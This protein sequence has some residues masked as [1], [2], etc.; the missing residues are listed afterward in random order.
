[1]KILIY[2]E[3]HLTMSLID[4]MNVQK[5]KLDYIVRITGDALLMK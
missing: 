3:A 4:I 5:F 1:M 2:L